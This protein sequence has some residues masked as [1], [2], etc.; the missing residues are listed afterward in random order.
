ML[1]RCGR[2][3]LAGPLNIEH[4]TSTL[5]IEKKKEEKTVNIHNKIYTRRTH[6][7]RQTNRSHAMHDMKQQQQ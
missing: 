1:M 6:T 7:D 3:V 2:F 4:R 5:Y